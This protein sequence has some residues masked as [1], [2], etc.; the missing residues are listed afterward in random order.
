MIDNSQKGISVYIV[1]MIMTIL[2]VIALGMNTLLISQIKMLRGMGD[3][4]VAFYAADTGI[5]RAL[6]E[7]SQGAET[8][9]QFEQTLENSSK[10]IVKIIAPGDDCLAENYCIISKGF[11][12]ETK[13]AIQITR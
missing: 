12:E 2:L 8:G 1:F 5:D 4:V 11:Y 6:Y 9:E 3:S 13:R 10:Y 7:I